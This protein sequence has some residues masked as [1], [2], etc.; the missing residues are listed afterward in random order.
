MEWR[1]PLIVG[2]KATAYMGVRSVVKKGFDDA[3]PM[4]FVNQGIEISNEDD[5]EYAI[6]EERTHV[7]LALGVNQRKFRQGK[8]TGAPCVHVASNQTTVIHSAWST[9]A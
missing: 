3:V 4:V 8:S 7:Y 1:R 6:L 5:E 2:G 9:S